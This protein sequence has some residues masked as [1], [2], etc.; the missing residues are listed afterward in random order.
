MSLGVTVRA[1]AVVRCG[2]GRS[3]RGSSYGRSHWQ[4]VVDSDAW[5]RPVELETARHTALGAR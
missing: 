5:L 4:A 1:S 3:G 2:T